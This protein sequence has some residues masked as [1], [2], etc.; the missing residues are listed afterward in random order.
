MIR[1]NVNRRFSERMRAACPELFKQKKRFS[2]RMKPVQPESDA[3]KFR[4]TGLCG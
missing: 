1:Q 4:S 2:F 3:V